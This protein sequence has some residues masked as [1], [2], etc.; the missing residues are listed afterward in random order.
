MLSASQHAR[1]TLFSQQSGF[2]IQHS[3]FGCRGIAWLSRIPR[4]S[5]LQ[6]SIHRLSKAWRRRVVHVN[7]HI[8]CCTCTITLSYC[9]MPDLIGWKRLFRMFGALATR[10]SFAHDHHQFMSRI[11]RILYYIL[12]TDVKLKSHRQIFT[13]STKE[14]TATPCV[15]RLACLRSGPERRR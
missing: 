13:M 8:V 12:E 2:M 10:Q 4:A 7:V 6:V 1:A 3:A 15:V 5:R 11:E 14:I 9:A